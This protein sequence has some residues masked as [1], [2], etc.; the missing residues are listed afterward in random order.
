M[1]ESFICSLQLKGHLLVHPCQIK[2]LQTHHNNAQHFLFCC[3]LFF[4]QVLCN[5]SL[6]NPHNNEKQKGQIYLGLYNESDGRAGSRIS[7]EVILS[8][9][10]NS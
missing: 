6:I 5:H 2:E 10:L 9:V 1:K 8:L 4:S 3:V 7:G